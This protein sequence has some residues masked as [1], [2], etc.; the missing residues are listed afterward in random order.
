MVFAVTDPARGADGGVTC[1]LV[2]RD[3]GWKS[4]PIP[5]MGEWGPASLVFEDVRVPEQ[6]IL[7]ELGHGF[8]LAMEAG[9][10]LP[11]TTSFSTDLPDAIAMQVRTSTPVR[12]LSGA[13]PTVDLLRVG[14]ARTPAALIA[15]A[16]P[17]ASTA[18]VT[19]P[20]L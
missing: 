6:N 13:L 20:R 5:T 16:S 14:T 12:V 18:G 7:G 19:W 10:Q 2:D 17:A 11:L 3:M 9:A 8:S 1:F 4:E 15:T